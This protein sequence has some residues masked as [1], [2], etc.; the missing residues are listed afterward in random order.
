M[1]RITIKDVAQLAGVSTATV[2]RA[3][4][5]PQ[6]VNSTTLENIQRVMREKHYVYNAAAAD[7]S[8]SKSTVVG[9]FIPTTAGTV[10]AGT[11]GAIEEYAYERGYPLMVCN[12]RYDPDIEAALLRQC[13]ERRVAGLILTGYCQAN[14]GLLVSLVEKG[15]PC[16]IVWE[17]L[18]DSLPLSYVGFDN[19]QAAFEVTDYLLGLGHR[20]VGLIVGPRSGIYRARRRSDGYAAALE[21]RGIPY[22][23]SLV[24]EKQPSML[25]GKE[26]MS[27][28]LRLPKPPTAVFAASD[29]L[30]IG[31]MAA[32]REAGLRVPEDVSVAGFD[33]I[34][35]ASY[36]HPPLTTVHVPSKD[37]GRMAVNLLMELIA[38]E[39]DSPRRVCLD[40]KM[41]LRKSCGKL[42]GH[43]GRG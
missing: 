9:V 40:T 30:A 38:G 12:T 1:A 23:P 37:I 27:R 11:V 4:R 2:S 26:A 5:S 41:I 33:D 29:F 13:M 35:F 31:A 39:D 25:N 6:L 43:S 19:Y 18:P 20:S 17:K 10:F 32:V 42:P 21:A 14:E 3:M 22:D 28:L 16:L 36:C 34:E 15:L 8:R 24:I 7:F